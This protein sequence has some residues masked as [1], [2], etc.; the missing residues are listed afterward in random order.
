MDWAIIYQITALLALAL[1]AIVITIFVLASSLLGLAVESAAKEDK[2]RRAAQDSEIEK[3]V[4]QAK[5]DLNNAAEGT[6]EFE[7]AAKTLRNLIN[8]KKKFE[9]ETKRIRRGYEVFTPKGGV[10]YPGIPLLASLV[11]STL[12]WGFSMGTYQSV[13]P[14]LWG[15]GVAALVFSLY[16]IYFGLK[17]IEKVAVTSEQ[18]ALTRMTRALG[19]ALKTHDEAMKPRLEFKFLDKEPPFHTS[20]ESTSETRYKI[21]LGHGD[22]LRGAEIWFI[23]PPDFSFPDKKAGLLG[24]DLIEKGFSLAC[25][26]EFE[27]IIPQKEYYGTLKLRTPARTGTFRLGYG[28][29]YEGCWS[30]FQYFEVVVE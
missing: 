8:K 13:S 18:A 7:Q 15:F 1:L 2:D 22:S 5:M 21:E 12:A 14:Y 4:E 26:D 25:C 27:D 16:R 6:G 30:E 23:A 19:T 9:K 3:Q 11:L 20:K 17:K 10:L 28:M 29:R 24:A